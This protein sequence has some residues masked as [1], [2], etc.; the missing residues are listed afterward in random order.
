M[1]YDRFNA[2]YWSKMDV[3]LRQGLSC[4]SLWTEIQSTLK[5]QKCTVEELLQCF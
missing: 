5:V 1:D 4:A 3:R 2:V